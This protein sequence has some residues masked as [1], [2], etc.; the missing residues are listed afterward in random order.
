MPELLILL[1][2]IQQQAMAMFGSDVSVEITTDNW[3]HVEHWGI[4]DG[5]AEFNLEQW[6]I[7]VARVLID[8]AP[9]SIPEA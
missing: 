1:P 7:L 3:I 5:W 9:P 6:M 8:L 4:V 2:S